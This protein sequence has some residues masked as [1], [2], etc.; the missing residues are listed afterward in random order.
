MEDIRS[1]NDAVQEWHDRE[2]LTPQAERWIFTFGFGHTHPITGESLA[3]CYVVIHGTNY[4]ARDEMVRRFGYK[5]A[6]QYPSEEKAGVEKW[7]LREI[8]E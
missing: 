5:W 4:E 7:S 1:C 2:R 8:E 6:F 3:K